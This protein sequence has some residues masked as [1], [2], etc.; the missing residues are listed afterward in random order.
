MYIRLRI[1]SAVLLLAAL[2]LVGARLVLGAEDRADSDPRTAVERRMEITRRNY[3]ATIARCASATGFDELSMAAAMRAPEPTRRRG[4]VHWDPGESA[5][6]STEEA[7]ERGLLGMPDAFVESR[8]GTF[9]ESSP[10]LDRAIRECRYRTDVALGEDFMTTFGRWTTLQD[11]IRKEFLEAVLPDADRVLERLLSCVTKA[12]DVEDTSLE[13]GDFENLLHQLRVKP[14][15]IDH[16]ETAVAVRTDDALIEV[17]AH[18]AHRPSTDEQR[19]AR[20]FVACAESTNFE[21]LA[22]ELQQPHRTTIL[23][24]FREELDQW[25]GWSAAT[26]ERLLTLNFTEAGA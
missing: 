3:A 4:M 1:I 14:G 24:R 13:S 12:L 19:V 20:V 5:P 10:A 9:V 8:A 23:R 15:R 7:N 2:Y 25:L 26:D 21:S 6:L 16:E 17:P 11:Q 18:A 22:L